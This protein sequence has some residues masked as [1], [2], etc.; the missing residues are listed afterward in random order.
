MFARLN[1]LTSQIEKLDSS[2]HVFIGTILSKNGVELT[3]SPPQVL[4]NMSLVPESTVEKVE[5][6]VA[7]AFEQERVLAER[8]RMAEKMRMLLSPENPVSS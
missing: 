1:T 5:T 6:Y 3:N 2:H 7:Y 8:D 4:V